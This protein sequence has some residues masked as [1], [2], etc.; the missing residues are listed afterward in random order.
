MDQTLWRLDHPRPAAAW[1]GAWTLTL[2]LHPFKLRGWIQN[3]VWAGTVLPSQVWY[4]GAKST[5]TSHSVA[6]G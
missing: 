2:Q 6:R 5:V 4:S 3:L 1:L